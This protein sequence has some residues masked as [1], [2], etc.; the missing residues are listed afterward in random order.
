MEKRGYIDPDWTP[1]TEEQPTEKEGCSRDAQV[2]KL[3]NDVN[4]RITD[5]I[6]PVIKCV[7]DPGT[8]CKK[9]A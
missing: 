2:D 3:D 6:K 5:A 8:C 4:K 1:D 9:N 7:C